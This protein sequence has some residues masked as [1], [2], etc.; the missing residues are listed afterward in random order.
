MSTLQALKARL[1][2]NGVSHILCEGWSVSP[3]SGKPVVACEVPQ[4]RER[5]T[6]QIR[7]ERKRRQR[8]KVEQLT[9]FA[10]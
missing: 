7:A 10:A 6:G 2:S 1:L 5:G 8:L 3:G 4:N 9:K